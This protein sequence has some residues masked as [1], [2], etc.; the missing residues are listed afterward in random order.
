MAKIKY[1]IF[2]LD[3]TLLN[4]LQD[5]ADAVNVM[6]DYFKLPHKTLEEIRLAIGNGVKVLC[7]KCLPSHY[8]NNQYLEGFEIFRNY[9]L[10]HS[11][12]HTKPYDNIILTCQNLKQKGYKIAVATN[13]L[14][15]AAQELVHIYFG[16]LFDYIQGT[17]EKVPTKPSPDIIN[18]I[19]QHLNIKDKEEI[20]YIGDSD[21]DYQTA[22]NS[23]I[24]LA[25]VT[26][27]YRNK[28]ELIEKTKRDDLIFLDSPL[29]LL[30]YL[31]NN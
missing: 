13:K 24:N 9:Y 29:D 11:N 15:E 23:N 7:R 5:L 10:N 26:Y 27:G 20:L 31:D 25:L 1:I 2:D 17:S 19:C 3:G 16:D 21:V 12:D 4:T 28:K 14:N 18:I 30:V 6:L 22:C 8:T